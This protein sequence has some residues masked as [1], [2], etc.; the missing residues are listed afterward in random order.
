ANS[1]AQTDTDTDTDTDTE[2]SVTETPAAS[3]QDELTGENQS[4]NND[5]VDSNS[6]AAIDEKKTT[7]TTSDDA[8]SS[9]AQAEPAIS[10]EDFRQESQN[11]LYRETT[12]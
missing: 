6:N 3:Q 9:E 1:N 10:Y 12:D 5:I 8:V 7:D 11:T 2:L 4:A